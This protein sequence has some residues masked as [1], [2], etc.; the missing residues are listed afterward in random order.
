MRRVLWT[1]EVAA[2]DYAG[3]GEKYHGAILEQYKI[4]VE[5]ADRVSARR[6]LTN[7]Y[8]VTLNTLI[9]TVIGLFWRG[10]AELAAWQLTIPLA[11]LL[12]Q[13]TAWFLLLRSYR[14]L[15]TIKYAV[16]GALEE[17]LPA[18]P[19][20]RAEWSD[21]SRHRPLTSFEQWIPVSFAL[22]YLAAFLAEL[23]R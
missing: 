13:C 9:P 20:W 10:R 8:F 21:P 12:L 23:L 16:I 19:Y 11:A 3:P 5:M 2:A 6:G 1:R 22:L 17:R 15:N 18:S 4:Y 14:R 7:T